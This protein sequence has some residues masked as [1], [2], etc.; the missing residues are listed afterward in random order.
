MKTSKTQKSIDFV[1]SGGGPKGA[2]HAGFLKAM[3]DSKIRLGTGTGISIGSVV[4]ALYT[5]G[6]KPEEI[7]EILRLQFERLRAKS[8]GTEGSL[9]WPSLREFCNGELLN[10]LP[11]F[12]RLCAEYGLKP[13]T[14]MQIVAY[15][16]LHRRPK[17]FS[18]TNYDLAKAL[19][20]SCA[21]PG[22]MRPVI[23]GPTDSITSWKQLLSVYKKMQKS[24]SDDQG[25]YFDGWMHHPFAFEFS[26]KPVIIS[27]LST[28]SSMTS[29]RWSQLKPA[30]LT[31][32]L[33]ELAISRL[34]LL[35][36]AMPD[37]R[38]GL[39]IETGLPSIPSVAWELPPEIH[40]ELF[41]HAFHK[42]LKS[43][44]TARMSQW[45]SSEYIS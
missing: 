15:D 45:L 31:F 11:V 39:V 36:P 14:N 12:R 44:H 22:I 38:E 24:K 4:L 41:D 6:Y 13:Q 34:S 27:R 9:R 42:T 25:I 5:N 3:E 26:S 23:D 2:G 10:M 21:L 35:S 43:I 16:I 19:T 37:P 7:R 1:L 32:H 17:V 28:G 33:F 8:K 20:A 30:D 18:G 29:E 40:Q